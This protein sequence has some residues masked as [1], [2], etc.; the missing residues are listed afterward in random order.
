MIGC[1]IAI[2]KILTSEINDIM[3][4]IHTLFGCWA[5]MKYLVG[6]NNK[7]VAYPLDPGQTSALKMKTRSAQ[8]FNV[9]L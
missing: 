5:Q 7:W 6:R 3:A 2:T 1:R 9:Y 4:A 8:S